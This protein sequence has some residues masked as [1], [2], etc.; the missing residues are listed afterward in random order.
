MLRQGDIWAY[1]I[2]FINLKTILCIQGKRK[3]KA[4]VPFLLLRILFQSFP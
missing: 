2:T 1:Y 3:R 4:T